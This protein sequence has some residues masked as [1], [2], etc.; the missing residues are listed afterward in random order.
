MSARAWFEIGRAYAEIERSR[1]YAQNRRPGYPM[2]EESD[3]DQAERKALDG[4]MLAEMR[5]YEYAL[6]RIL[7]SVDRVETGRR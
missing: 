7:D 5:A 6:G 2:D 3:E 1:S 4:E